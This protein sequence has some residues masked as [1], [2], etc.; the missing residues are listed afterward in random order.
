MIATPALIGY[1][2]S[3]KTERIE[4]N[5]FRQIIK[6]HKKLSPVRLEITRNLAPEM[7]KRLRHYFELEKE[8]MFISCAPLDLSFVDGIR[9][10]MREK[11]EL[12]FGP[13]T[14]QKTPLLKENEALIPQILDHDVLVE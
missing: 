7:S 11:K 14:P 4:S 8:R 9:D 5:C 13:R 10:I 12:F 2:N 1:D 6:Q 3:H